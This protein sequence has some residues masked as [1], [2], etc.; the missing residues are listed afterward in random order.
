MKNLLVLPYPGGE[1]LFDDLPNAVFPLH[2]QYNP[3][4]A[5]IAHINSKQS[6]LQPI[7]LAEVKLSQSAVCLHQLGELDVPDE[8]YLHKVP[9]E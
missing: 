7:R 5:V 2:P 9:F 3:V 6:F 1:L 4:A 8:L